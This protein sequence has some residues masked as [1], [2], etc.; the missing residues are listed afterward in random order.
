[1]GTSTPYKT[2]PII[3]WY[4]TSDKFPPVGRRILVITKIGKD[5]ERA[6]DSDE[7]YKGRKNS[8]QDPNLYYWSNN[9]DF[10]DVLYWAEMPNL[11]F[12]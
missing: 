2:T 5:G 11:N 4:T 9:V 12:K 7:L 8:R 1:M 3:R 6:I 10:D